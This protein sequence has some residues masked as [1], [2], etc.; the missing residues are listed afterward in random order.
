MRLRRELRNPRVVAPIVAVLLAVIWASCAGAVPCPDVVFFRIGDQSAV[1]GWTMGVA[2]HEIEDFGGY[3]LWKREVW[4][5]PDADPYSDEEPSWESFSLVREYVL[6]EDDP[7]A[8]GYWIFPAF[9]DED[10][11][12]VEWNGAEC[13]SFVQGVRRDSAAIFQNVFPYEF[14]VTAFSASD[15]EAV[16]DTC[17]I[18]TRTGIIYPRVGTR[19]DLSD[20]RCIPNP[21]RASA[22]WE[23]GGQ[24][25]VAFIG[26]PETAKIRIYTVAADL[27]RTIDHDNAKS[28]LEDLAFWDLKNQDKQEVAPGVYIYLVESAGLGSIE[29]KVMII[30]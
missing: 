6:D 23:Y 8:A 28:G 4:L 26:L 2:E 10:P 24:R 30:K 7:D 27:V 13:D 5:D 12:C 21:Y 29:G 17:V 3:R 18:I 25:R 16:N 14:A 11:V 1:M 9:W 15:P 20:V 22:D 19:D